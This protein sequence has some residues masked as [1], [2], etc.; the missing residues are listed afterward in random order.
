MRVR[1]VWVWVAGLTALLGCRTDSP[2]ASSNRPLASADIAGLP[3][4]SLQSRCGHQVT[5]VAWDGTYYYVA[6]GQ[7]SLFNCISRYTAAGEY[8]DQRTVAVD[9]RGLHYVPA[10]GKLVT[11]HYN[12]GLV[13]ID[14]PTGVATVIANYRTGADQVAPAPDPAGTTYW[15]INGTAAEEHRLSDDG[16]VSAI[17]VTTTD[18]YVI[19]VSDR[20]IFAVDGQQ[21]RIY[22]KK[23]G[24]QIRSQMLPE[25]L[26]CQGFG[27]S[28]NGDRVLYA[29]SCTT[30][31][32]AP[33]GLGGKGLLASCGR[34][35]TGV[36]WDG[37]YYYL[38]EGQFGLY[39]CISRFT[40]DSSFVDQRLVAIDMRGLHYV[41]ATG[42]LVTRHYNGGL[43]AV[44]Y[45]SGATSVI[46]P[47][48]TGPDQV[49]PAPDP[50]GD[51]Y[52][53]LATSTAEQHTLSD[54]TL[55][56][57]F[58]VQ[59][60][61]PYVIAA[62]ATAV[63]TVTGSDV[64]EYDK[65]T[66]T[67]IRVEP[68]SVGLGCQGWG[69]GVSAAG[70][71]LLVARTCDT[72]AVLPISPIAPGQTPGGT[73]V[74]VS[75]IDPL[76]GGTPVAVTFTSV[77]AAGT[78]TVASGSSGA[79][80]PTGFR[81]GSPPVYWDVATTAS[82]SGSIQLCF[83][84]NPGAYSHPSNVRLFHGTGSSWQDITTSNDISTGVVCGTASSLSPFT[85]AE[86]HYDV[87]GFFA[88]VETAPTVNLLQPGAAV[89]LKFRLGGDAGL[90]VLAATSPAS[91]PIAC[92][93]SAAVAAMTDASTAQSAALAYDA[94][95]DQYILVWKTSKTWSGTCRR[96][97]L[98][99][100]DGQVLSADFR[101]SK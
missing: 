83:R 29:N 94:I 60:T 13:A 44:D 46:A 5:G 4:G 87:A 16:V 1:N 73:G 91:V 9:M 76:A 49:Q 45:A 59:S 7:F 86:L 54:N 35:L 42:K 6:E 88:P 27:A 25:P 66:G 51:T 39:N 67:L 96:L 77:S 31:D 69:F 85:L 11:R 50:A 33:T 70:D 28:S 100:R 93:S 30:A 61:N 19:A 98:T 92:Q 84:Y 95:A 63:Y 20:W 38:A 81:L 43:I 53:I 64:A 47:Y 99:L 58:A 14:Y 24:V 10:T 37:S 80:L 65:A 36:A 8:L 89:P 32:V 17:A 75:P 52:W 23:T 78:T 97:V 2:T 3:A 21:V 72:A 90:D 41:P 18:P 68:L 71:R 82:Y 12:G 62:S 48:R 56:R 15:I 26:G 79:P 55:V 57:S 74:I 101:F 40:A 34:Q 22:S